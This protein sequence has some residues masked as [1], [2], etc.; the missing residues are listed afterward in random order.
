MWLSR[1]AAQSR[2]AEGGAGPGVVSVGGERPAVVTDAEQ[3]EARVFSPGG[4]AW[5]PAAEQTVLIVRGSEPCVAGAAQADA[6]D[7]APGEVR[8]FSRGASIVL[9][10]GGEVRVTG[11]LLVNGIEVKG[12]TSGTETL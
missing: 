10:N 3:R 7:L 12:E 1:Q 8:I 5:R 9:T 4:Y 2:A 6:G 11:R